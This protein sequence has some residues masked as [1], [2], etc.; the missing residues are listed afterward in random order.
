MWNWLRQ[1][2][3][4]K[5]FFPPMSKSD[6]YKW[7]WR[8]HRLTLNPDDT[9]EDM[10]AQMNHDQI[11]DLGRKV[12]KIELDRRMSRGNMIKDLKSKVRTL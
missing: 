4:P 9:L 12:Y 7:A 11:E 10:I 1:W 8:N 6:L 5:E 3:W 2:W